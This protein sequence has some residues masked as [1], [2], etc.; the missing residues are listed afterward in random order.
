[1]GFKAPLKPVVGYSL[2]VADSSPA[3]QKPMPN[4]ASAEEC[5]ALAGKQNASVAAYIPSM[6]VCTVF[7]DSKGLKLSAPANPNLVVLSNMELPVA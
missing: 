3:I 4:V 1:M 5:S 6:K 7:T 2:D